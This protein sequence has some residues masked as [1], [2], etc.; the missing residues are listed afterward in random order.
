MKAFFRVMIG[1]VL[2]MSALGFVQ[3]QPG[4]I[5]GTVTDDSTGLPLREALVRFF[6]PEGLWSQGTHT[7]SNGHIRGPRCGE[8][9]GERFAVWIHPPPLPSAR[10]T[11]H[12]LAHRLRRNASQRLKEPSQGIPRS[13]TGALMQR[14]KEQIHAIG[15]RCCPSRETDHVDR[16]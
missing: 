7:D 1:L 14:A 8:G 4:S 16:W 5:G 11:K 9:G 10:V 6:R 12:S 2:L 13:R 15:R 3:A